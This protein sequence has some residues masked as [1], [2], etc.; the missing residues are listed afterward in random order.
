M[1]VTQASTCF[2]YF[3]WWQSLCCHNKNHPES[4]KPGT[5]IWSWQ[6]MLDCCKVLVYF[7]T[8]THCLSLTC[9]HLLFSSVKHTRNRMKAMSRKKERERKALKATAGTWLKTDLVRIK[10]QLF[11]CL[12]TCSCLSYC[13]QSYE[14]TV[15]KQ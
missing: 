3:W 5:V 14:L 7:Q 9:T 8:Y 4:W 10:P 1:Q 11:T 13:R 2:F 6:V 15:K 12:E